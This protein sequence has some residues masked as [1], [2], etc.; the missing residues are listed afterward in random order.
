MAFVVAPNGDQQL[1]KDVNPVGKNGTVKHPQDL[2]KMVIVWALNP[3]TVETR[4]VV[5]HL[6]KVYQIAL[7]P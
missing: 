2:S 5:R 3:A 7:T 4:E 6:K 1:S